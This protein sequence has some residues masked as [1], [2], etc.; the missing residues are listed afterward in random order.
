MSENDICVTAI[1]Q[2]I[3]KLR[4]FKDEQWNFQT[5]GKMSFSDFSNSPNDAKNDLTVDH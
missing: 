5:S 4:E 1:N 2:V 3:L